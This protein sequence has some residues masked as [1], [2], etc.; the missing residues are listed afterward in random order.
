MKVTHLLIPLCLCWFPFNPAQSQQ[1]LHLPDTLS[2]PVFNLNIRDSSKVFFAGFSTTTIGINADYLGPV[3]FLNKGDSIQF[4]VT[5]HLS[6]TTTLHWHGLHVSPQNDGGPHVTILPGA[7]WSPAFTVRD[8]A[9]THWYHPHLHMMTNKHVS[10]GATGMIIVRDSIESTL[11]LPRTYGTDDFPLIVQTKSFD[12]S[13]QISFDNPFDSTVVVNGSI[14]PI[15]NAPAQVIRLRILNA[16]SERV[17]NIGFQGNFSFNL[18]GT[19][20]GLLE[21]PVLLSRLSLSPGERAEILL[22]LGGL[23]GQTLDM[24]SFA[25]QLPNAVYGASQPGMGPGQIIP[26]YSTNPL[27]GADFRL[28]RIQ[29]QAAGSNP[30]SSIPNTLVPSNP[31]PPGSANAT[32]SLTFMPMNMGPTAIQ[33]PFMINNQMFDQNII[34]YTIPLGNTE[35]WTLTNQS[36]I[37]H[38]F[39]I[40]NTSFTILDINGAPFISRMVNEVL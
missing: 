30:I 22:D 39:H 28:L 10:R 3:L 29:V 32:R 14:D 9:S 20:G 7:T 38:P 18:I 13:N 24:I 8:Q 37:A 33:G 25:S 27:N 35:I 23:N 2:G 26:G 21:A 6:D 17:F 12:T 36:P 19:D 16:A 5:N 40:H 34:N 31:I 1:S 15:L 4:H 11:A